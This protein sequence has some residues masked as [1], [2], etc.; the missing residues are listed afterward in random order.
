MAGWR[1][2]AVAGVIG[3]V[4]GAGAVT[5]VT[6][7]GGEHDKAAIG[8]VVHDYVLEHP[9]ILPEAMDRLRERETVKLVAAHRGAIEKPFGNAWAGAANGDVT[10]VEFTDF[11]CGFCRAS[12]PRVDRLLAGDPRLKVVYRE[13]PI[14][15]E[16]SL[17]AAKVALAAPSP[18]RYGLFRETLYGSGQPTPAALSA[19]ATKAGISLASADKPAINDEISNNLALGRLLGLSGTPTFIVGDRVLSGAVSYETLKD[20]VAAA[21]E[22]KG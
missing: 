10:L 6:H 13:W 11:A 4:V 8:Q 22:K 15:S 18:A 7:M 9:E 2:A 3:A 21:R 1:E 14:L 19:A 20:A 5:L 17:A 16:G 12:L